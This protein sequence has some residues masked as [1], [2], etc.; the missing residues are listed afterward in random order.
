MI[1]KSN[2]KELFLTFILILLLF[3]NVIGRII[4]LTLMDEVIFFLVLILGLYKIVFIKIDSASFVV[5]ALTILLLFIGL[6]STLINKY[7]TNFIPILKDIIA[8]AKLPLTFSFGIYLFNNINKKLVFKYLIFFIKI[9]SCIIFLF[10]IINLFVD[11]GMDCGY[12]H[13]VKTFQFLFSHPTFLVYSLVIFISILFIDKSFSI[14]I[15]FNLIS[16][17]LSMRDKAFV[18]ILLYFFVLFLSK[19]KSFRF[20]LLFGAFA[21]IVSA[22][23]LFSVSYDKLLN[24]YLVYGTQTARGALYIYGLNYMVKCFPFGTGFATWGGS[25]AGEYYSILYIENNM[26]YTPGIMPNDLAYATDTYWPLI[27]TEFGFFGLL[28]YLLI[29]Y[30]IFMYFYSRSTKTYKYFLILIFGYCLIASFFEGFFTNDSGVFTMLFLLILMKEGR[31]L[32]ESS[33]LLQRK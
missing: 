11:I 26:M 15:G 14:W 29:L 23:I 31:I 8:V 30:L 17:L 25:A 1:K 19:I 27:Y 33:Y 2:L 28:I 22:I 5:F 9:F 13:G 32:Y 20:K 16:L 7:Q 24:L 3:S 6:V 10:A 18:F 12:R 4:P 21:V